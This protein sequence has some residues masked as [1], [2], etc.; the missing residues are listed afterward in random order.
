MQKVFNNLI[1]GNLEDAKKGAKRYNDASL[2]AFAFYSLG[3]TPEMA[4]AAAAFLK[5]SGSFQAYCDAK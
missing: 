3:F 5:G 4:D 2:R 1:N